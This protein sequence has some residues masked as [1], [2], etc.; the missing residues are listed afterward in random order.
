MSEENSLHNTQNDVIPTL[1]PEIEAEA[2]TY[3]DLSEWIYQTTNGEPGLML[4]GG[5]PG[6]QKNTLADQIVSLATSYPEFCPNSIIIIDIDD[7]AQQLPEPKRGGKEKYDLCQQTVMAALARRQ[8]VIVTAPFPLKDAQR[9]LWPQM[10]IN[11]HGLKPENVKR[12]W[13]EISP[14]DAI[15]AAQE[16]QKL[17]THIDSNRDP[18]T[19]VHGWLDKYKNQLPTTTDSQ[20]WIILKTQF[21][22]Q[23]THTHQ[24]KLQIA[25]AHKIAN[26]HAA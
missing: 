16:R 23:P 22:S 18:S 24:K 10:A 1:N 12:V 2:D 8:T 26:T 9:D 5:M 21:E 3:T 7:I 20:N 25:L 6:S 14:E 13:L 11:D 17:G 15:R 4:I 19:I